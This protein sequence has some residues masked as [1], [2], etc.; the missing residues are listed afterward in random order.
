RRSRRRPNA[1]D[2]I[3]RHHSGTR[4]SVPAHQGDR[5]SLGVGR[6]SCA[7]PCVSRGS[8]RCGSGRAVLCVLFH[9]DRTACSAHDHWHWCPDRTAPHGAAPEVLKGLLLAGRNEWPL[10]AFRRYCVDLPIPNTLHCRNT[11][12]SS[13]V[14]SVRT[15]RNVF[16]ALMA[17]LV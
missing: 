11:L 6:T 13:P 10:L 1:A 7:W 3:P 15:Y 12:M 5:V 8:A 9:H 14:V 4:R 17:L 2:A 16:I